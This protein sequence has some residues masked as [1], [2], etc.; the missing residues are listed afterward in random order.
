MIP[1]F[2]FQQ[3]QDVASANADSIAPVDYPVVEEEGQQVPRSTV[4]VL[5]WDA[6][7]SNLSGPNR[8]SERYFVAMTENYYMSYPQFWHRLP[9][10]A[11]P[12][13]QGWEIYNEWVRQGKPSSYTRYVNDGMSKIDALLYS[14]DIEKKRDPEML[15]P[16]GS[17]WVMDQE[18]KFAVEA[19]IDYWA[20]LHYKNWEPDWSGCLN[21]STQ[22]KYYFTSQNKMGLRW[23]TILDIL[24]HYSDED[25]DWLIE[26]MLCESGDY[27]TVLDG[28]PLIYL[29]NNTGGNDAV[30]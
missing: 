2:A 28:R 7:I 21:M 10:F 12:S 13:E 23:C 29:L 9:W 1:A 24:S 27:F 22:S 16:G 30:E 3:I 4:G 11:Q 17:Q 6:Q 25:E 15:M 14:S 19:G 5:R 18:I 20:I 26:M 8:G